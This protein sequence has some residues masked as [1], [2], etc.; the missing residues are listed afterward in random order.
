MKNTMTM[1]RNA[2]EEDSLTYLRVA[3]YLN[4]TKESDWAVDVCIDDKGRKCVVNHLIESDCF[5]SVNYHM[6][7]ERLCKRFLYE[8]N[9]GLHPDY[10][11]DTARKRCTAFYMDMFYDYKATVQKAHR[12][13]KDKVVEQNEV[14]V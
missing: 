5:F 12:Y 6:R 3:Q 7:H 11:Q 13:I 8:I 10:S 9:D 14:A 4:A 1:P 2:Q